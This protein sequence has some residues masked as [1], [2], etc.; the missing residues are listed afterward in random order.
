[1]IVTLTVKQDDMT[2]AARRL[3]SAVSG[4]QRRTVLHAMGEEFM[5]LTLQQFGA[6]RPNRA[7]EWDEL[8]ERY[9]KRIKYDGPPKLILTGSLEQSFSLSVSDSEAVVTA[10]SGYAATHQFGRGPIPARP[11]F[12][13]IDGQLTDYAR[14]RIVKRAEETIMRIAGG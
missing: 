12:P 4:G 10:N 1:M 8:S 5:T 14:E 2:P 13:V 7:A 3:L 6:D 11:F 9:K